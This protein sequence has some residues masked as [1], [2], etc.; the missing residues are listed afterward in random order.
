MAHLQKEFAWSVCNLLLCNCF[1]LVTTFVIW[2]FRF[3]KFLLAFRQELQKLFLLYQAPSTHHKNYWA[4]IPNRIHK[5]GF[6]ISVVALFTV[7]EQANIH[8]RAQQLGKLKTALPILQR[9]GTIG[10]RYDSNNIFLPRTY[11]SEYG[12]WRSKWTHTHGCTSTSYILHPGAPNSFAPLLLARRSQHCSQSYGQNAA[13][14]H[15]QKQK[16]IAIL[17]WKTRCF[18]CNHMR[19]TKTLLFCS[20]KSFRL[21]MPEKSCMKTCN[22]NLCQKNAHRSA[23]F[24]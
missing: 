5:S 11:L 7:A 12:N 24:N 23:W 2:F 19:V 21:E 10:F 3:Y 1:L 22:K 20:K 9:N 8:E 13:A 4:H 15:R 18:N 14:S 6:S 17:H 16:P